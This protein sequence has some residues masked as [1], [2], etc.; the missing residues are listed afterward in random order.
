MYEER[1]L[2]GKV[3]KDDS[4]VKNVS[5]NILNSKREKVKLGFRKLLVKQ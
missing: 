1:M 3:E 2:R 4:I 5:L